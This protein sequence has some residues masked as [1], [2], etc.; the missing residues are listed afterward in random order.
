MLDWKFDSTD[1]IIWSICIGVCLAF[2]VSHIYKRLVGPLVRTLIAYDHVSEES[3]VTLDEIKMNKRLVRFI[4]K[5]KSPVM[6]YVSVVGGSIPRITEGKK[7]HYDYSSARFYVEEGKRE[8]VKTA[9]AEPERLIALIIYLILTLG[10]AY[11]L[12]RLVPVLVA[13]IS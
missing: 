4:L 10:C 9:F 2:V 7:S 8:K 5:D 3:A 13:L 12:T 11:G 6:G 1:F